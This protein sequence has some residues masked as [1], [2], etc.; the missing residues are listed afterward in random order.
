MRTNNCPSY[1]VYQAGPGSAA[2]EGTAR[3]HHSPE[4]LRGLIAQ[5]RSTGD[6][7]PLYRLCGCD[8]RTAEA[9]AAAEVMP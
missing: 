2:N 4:Y 1:T 5:A 9:R 7:A 6:F 3:P 8:D